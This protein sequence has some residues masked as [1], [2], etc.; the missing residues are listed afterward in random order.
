MAGREGHIRLDQR[1]QFDRAAVRGLFKIAL[2]TIAF[3]QGIDYAQSEEF[4][5]IRLFVRSNIREY[6]AVL[7]SGEPFDS[8]TNIA[9]G[10]EGRPPVITICIL[11]LGFIC[12]F[13]T[14]FVS[15]TEL[16]AAA[17]E[18]GEGATKIPN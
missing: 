1:L 2:E 4:D 3:S 18:I 13:D 14:N 10:A 12:D 5:G 9:R 6:A 7:A 16:L 15:G 8:Y 11:Q 17:A